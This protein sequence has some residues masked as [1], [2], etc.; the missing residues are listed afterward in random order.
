MPAPQIGNWQPFKS[1]GGMPDDPPPVGRGPVAGYNNPRF[2][3]VGPTQITPPPGGYQS[4]ISTRPPLD[5]GTQRQISSVKSPYSSYNQT[6]AN[7]SRSAFAR[8]LTDTSRN[9]LNRSSAQ[10]N[11][12]F[13]SQAEKSRS[14]D[15]LAQKQ[16]AA[17]RYRMNV[18][19]DIFDVDTNT[20]YSQGIMDAKQM[21]VTEKRN[22]EAKRTAMVLRMI[23]SLLF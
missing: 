1:G 20:R 17:D 13:Q 15:I 19:K 14:E 5:P 12:E 22:E 2:P 7:A 6:G 4:V 16:S 10:F 21:Y 3:T 18:F 23:G 11:K 8:A 9:E